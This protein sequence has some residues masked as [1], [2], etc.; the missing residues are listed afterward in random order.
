MNVV[1]ANGSLGIV[2]IYVLVGVFGYLTFLNFDGQPTTNILEA[3]YNHISE[4]FIVRLISFNTCRVK[5]HC[6][7]QY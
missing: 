3:P 7:S 6:L 5:S 1:F 4:L 2:I